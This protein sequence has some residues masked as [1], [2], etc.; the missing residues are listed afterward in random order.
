MSHGSLSDCYHALRF[1]LGKRQKI[2]INR[3]KKLAQSTGSQLAGNRTKK[4]TRAV[5]GM[6]ISYE[7]N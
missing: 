6:I 3:T 5:N 7:S 1:E 2:S 4:N